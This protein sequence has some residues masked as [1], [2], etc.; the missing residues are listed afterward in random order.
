MRA[1]RIIRP[2]EETEAS[3][4]LEFFDIYIRSNSLKWTHESSIY[5]ERNLQ[6]EVSVLHSKHTPQMR[7][8]AG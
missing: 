8:N 6:V 1:G 4:V 7:G 3:L 5:I 2:K